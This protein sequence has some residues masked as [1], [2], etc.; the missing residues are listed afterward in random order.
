MTRQHIAMLASCFVVVALVAAASAQDAPKETAEAPPLTDCDTYASNAED[1]D[2]VSA[3][4][5]GDKLEGAKAIPACEAAVKQYPNSRRLIYQ[6]GRSYY[7]GAKNYKQS[8]RYYQIAADLGSAAAQNDLAAA[9]YSGQGVPLDYST[10]FKYF[11][12]SAKLNFREAQ[13]NVGYMY[14]FGQGVP[15]SETIAFDW[16]NIAAENGL[17]G[18]LRYAAI[19]YLFGEGVAQDS[20]KAAEYFLM[21]LKR[22]D[23]ETLSKIQDYKS[24]RPDYYKKLIESSPE[25]AALIAARSNG[26]TQESHES[27]PINS[28]RALALLTSVVSRTAQEDHPSVPVSR[29]VIVAV[30]NVSNVELDKQKTIA[31]VNSG[32]SDEDVWTS[33][34]SSAYSKPPPRFYSRKDT[35]G[36]K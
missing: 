21:A 27:G 2:H 26:N 20:K 11:Y 28:A 14:L 7:Y 9:Y 33:C 8:V 3:S 19:A 35:A 22:G 1:P 34:R 31:P 30:P 13:R 29:P 32:Q 24:R 10:A 36:T 12:S 4:V 15:Q 23:A 6:L 25:L 17:P 18:G 16:Y 5:F